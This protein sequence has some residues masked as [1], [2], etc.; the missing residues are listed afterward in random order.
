VARTLAESLADWLRQQAGVP[1]HV[2]SA[3]LLLTTPEGVPVLLVEI[4]S[5]HH[6]DELARLSDSAYRD[7]VAELLTLGL[8]ELVSKKTS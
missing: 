3:P 4:G 2:Y 5:I 8:A 7:R 6:N 1:V